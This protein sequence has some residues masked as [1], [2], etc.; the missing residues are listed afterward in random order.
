MHI[1]SICVV[2]AG[3]N[4]AFQGVFQALCGGLE[5]L[6][7]SVCRQLLFIFPFAWIFAKMAKA[8]SGLSWTMWTVFP[9]GE[10][11]TAVVA[12][13]LFKRIYNKRVVLLKK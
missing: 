7:I 1:I 3:I 4:I 5:S 13:I 10:I 11:M 12:T 9:I 6:I 8:D 2:F